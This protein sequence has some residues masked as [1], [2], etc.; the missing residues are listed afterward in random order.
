MSKHNRNSITP[1]QYI[2][3]E[4]YLDSGNATRA[5]EKAGYSWPDKAGP[6]LRHTPKIAD[7]INRRMPGRMPTD[8]LQWRRNLRHSIYLIGAENG[9]VK[10][11]ISSNVERRIVRIRLISPVAIKLL[12]S[13]PVPNAVSV[14]REL[15]KQFSHKRQHGEWFSLS[16]ADVAGIIARFDKNE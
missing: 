10:I 8:A 14:E 3:I 6:R 13:I 5:A 4:E 2:F 7:I 16:R 9:L 11:G 12:F 1:Q 15:H